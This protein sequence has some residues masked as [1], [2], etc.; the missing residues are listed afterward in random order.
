MKKIKYYIPA[1]IWMIF[2]F[3]MSN[4]N[5][6]DSSAQ[7]NVLVD[8]VI[9]LVHINKETLSFLIRKA[10]HM[11]EY[12]ILLALLY[13]ALSKT[14]TYKYNLLLS[15][16]FAFLYACSDEFHQLFIPGRSGQ[17]RD[18]LI[19]SSGALIML[20]I[21]ICIKKIFLN[22]HFSQLKPSEDVYL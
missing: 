13:Y 3:M 4:A 1:I 21:I 15:F 16:I 11:S 8:L 7:S 5:G 6:N 18:V 19:D 2:I 12:A 17:F 9:N 10:S 22:R 14:F 20:L